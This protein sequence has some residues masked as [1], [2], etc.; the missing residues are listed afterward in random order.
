MIGHKKVHVAYGY[1]GL[2]ECMSSHRYGLAL[3][4]HG[5]S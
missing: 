4:V 1:I 2:P 5:F 3:K